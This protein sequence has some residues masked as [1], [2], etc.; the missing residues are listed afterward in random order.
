MPGLTLTLLRIYIYF[1]DLY[2]RIFRLPLTWSVFLPPGGSLSSVSQ[3]SEIKIDIYGFSNKPLTDIVNPIE[4]AIY[5]I[6]LN[7]RPHH[8]Y[9]L[10]Q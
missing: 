6:Y 1:T 10:F 3:F 5:I 9:E 7:I 2:C 8:P 4:K